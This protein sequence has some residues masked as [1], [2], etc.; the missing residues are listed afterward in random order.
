MVVLLFS[1]TEFIGRFHPVLVHLPVG[2][3]LLAVLFQWLSLKKQFQSLQVAVG[4]A[5]FCGM[6]SAVASCVSGYLLSTTDDYDKALIFKHQWFGI[7]V[8]ATSVIA[9]YLNKKN[10][11]TKWVM[12][13]MAL[14][15]ILTGHLGGSI[16]HG[17]DYLTKSFTHSDKEMGDTV[18]KPIPDV[19]E[20]V[21]YT[22]VIKPILAARCYGCH[23]PNKQK[24]KLR[25]D[26]PNFILKG[27]KDGEVIVAGK[28]EESALI[29]RIVLQKDNKDHMPPLEKPQLSKQ[30]IDLLHWW[31]TGG[32]DF[33]KKVKD[34]VQTKNIQP[35]LQ[36]VQSGKIKE[37]KTLATLPEQLVEKAATTAIQHLQAR[38]VAVI[39]VAQNSNYLSANFVAVDSFTEKDLQLL[40]PLKKQLIWLKLS[41]SAV[42]DTDLAAITRLPSLTRLFLDKTRVT[43]K[44]LQQLKNCLQL[45]YLN[46]VGTK[47][48]AKGLTQLTGLKNLQQ[49]YLYQTSISGPDWIYL[50][51]I[52]PKTFIDTGGYKI[53]QLDSDT[54]E[55]KKAPVN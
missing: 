32:A 31:I 14:L 1:I 49:L 39:P 41:N 29:K 28:A 50:K 18:Q 10:K 27:G 52:F 12:L 30:E 4:I 45:Q 20:A 53:Q 47:V 23:G 11:Q 13:P 54:V 48:T 6:L 38:G 3:L 37:E 5:L 35:I 51:K 9:W 22:A 43:D 21:A 26:E 40:E 36:S 55:L 25:L 7:A 24:G 2:I 44:G 16:T 33:N 42:A 15:I 34:I 46:L 8:A 17:S 19:Q